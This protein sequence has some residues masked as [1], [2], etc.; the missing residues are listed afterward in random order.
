MTEMFKPSRYLPYSRQKITNSDIKNI[1]KVLKSDFITQGP[2]ILEFEK[3]FAKYVNAKYA[4]SCAT[5]TAALHISCL[6]MGISH[7]S[8][9]AT[10]PITF[11]ASSNCAEFL[12]AK[13]RF[14]DVD[15]NTHCICP[16]ELEKLLKKEKIDLVVAIHMAGHSAEMKKLSNLK[17]KYKFKLIED[18]CHALGGKYNG[19]KV[20]SC[21]Y[22]DICTFSFHPVKP[23][24]TG[25]GGM[26]TTNNEKLY[27]KMLLYRTHGIHKNSKQFHNKKLAFDTNKKANRWYYEMSKLGYNYRITDIQAALGISQLKKINTFQKNRITI[28]K[29]YN[30]SF[31]K[32]DYLET[33]ITKNNVNHAYHLYTL[34]IDFKKLRKTKNEL[35]EEL[36]KL[37]IGTQVL[38]IPVFLQPY[39]KKKYNYKMKNF[40]NSMS[41]YNK[42]LSIPIF[43]DLSLQEQNYIIKKII[44]LIN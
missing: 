30:K 22:S 39:Y 40:P 27:K 32:I 29:K 24:T 1:N 31:K 37:S 7:K 8:K 21:K 3:K 20:G 4:I 42:A 11:V 13:T 44:S 2:T 19:Y 12:G 15:K 9:I 35:M 28:A 41:Y 38:Y 25:E 18:S 17:K 16:D 10:S 33:P 6:A 36:A 43:S 26:I 5:G 23:I 34:K 14:V